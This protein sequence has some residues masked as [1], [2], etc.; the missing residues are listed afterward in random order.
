MLAD[1]ERVEA[2][3]ALRDRLRRSGVDPFSAARGY[4]WDERM[5]PVERHQ[6]LSL[7]VLDGWAV[8]A[9]AQAESLLLAAL[10]RI[11]REPDVAA[12]LERHR[13]RRGEP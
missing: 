11:C 2:V 6:L 8:T 5:S 3:L 12:A 7:T 1:Q 10:A 13:P 9:A 4:R